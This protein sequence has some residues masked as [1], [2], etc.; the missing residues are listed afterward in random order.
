M[1][2]ATLIACFSVAVVAAV[3]V[4]AFTEA[5]DSKPTGLLAPGTLMSYEV[6]SK[7]GD[8]RQLEGEVV[9]L[10][11]EWMIMTLRMD[12]GRHHMFRVDKVFR[13]LGE[14]QVGDRV[15]VS[16]TGDEVVRSITKSSFHVREALS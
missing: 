12:N 4:S 2:V 10:D 9:S 7:A 3:T 14:I 6:H 5:E 13:R 1:K 11:L 15:E 8:L 16:L